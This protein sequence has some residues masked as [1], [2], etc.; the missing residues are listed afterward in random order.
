MGLLSLE[1]LE[2]ASIAAGVSSELQPITSIG[3]G[4]EYLFES[5]GCYVSDSFSGVK[6]TVC[7]DRMH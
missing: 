5:M 1:L 4:A 2:Q 6:R 7:V 3:T